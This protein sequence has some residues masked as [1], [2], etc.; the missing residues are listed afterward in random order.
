MYQGTPSAPSKCYSCYCRCV[1]QWGNPPDW[2]PVDDW[3]KAGNSASKRRRNMDKNIK[4]K[5]REN[6]GSRWKKCRSC[7]WFGLKSS[8]HHE[9]RMQKRKSWDKHTPPCRSWHPN[10]VMAVVPNSEPSININKSLLWVDPCYPAKT[11][12]LLDGLVKMI[13]AESL[14]LWPS[15]ACH[16]DALIAQRQQSASAKRW[17]LQLG[18]WVADG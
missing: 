1:G 6:S 17:T 14:R 3:G 9:L 8:Q 12:V 16:Q 18:M 13:S 11:P 7:L 10:S 2:R 15:R 5:T 4:Q